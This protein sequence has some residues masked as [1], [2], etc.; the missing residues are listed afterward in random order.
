[1]RPFYVSTMQ[2]C[3]RCQW[4]RWQIGTSINDTGGKFANAV[5]DTDGKQWEQ[6]SNCWQLKMNLKKKIYLNAYST[7]QRSPKEIMQ[8]FLIEDFFPFATSVNDTGGAPWA[9]NIS[10]NFRK[11]LK[12]P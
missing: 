12:R 7:T 4:R 10:A 9:P 11:N 1:M 5:N 8:I 2:I 3:H 6:L